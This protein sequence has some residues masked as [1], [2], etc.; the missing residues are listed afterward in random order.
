MPNIPPSPESVATRV[1]ALHGGRE[2]FLAHTD[3]QIEELN[4]KWNQNAALMGLILRSH[5]FV[6]YYLER[7]LRT[8]NPHLGSLENA[9]LT[10]AQKT[11]LMSKGDGSVAYL[12][13]GIKRLNKIRNR[14]AHTLSASIT[15][16]DRDVLLDI[17]IFRSLRDALASPGTPS[18]APIDVLESFAQHAGMV[19]DA[20][21]DPAAGYWVKALGGGE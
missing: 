7:Y 14:M 3:A 5:L 11:E 16:E 9:R 4:A 15:E 18:A 21:S 1:I 6:E 17:N 8:R 19:L 20:A 10:F 13:P 2:A 12:L